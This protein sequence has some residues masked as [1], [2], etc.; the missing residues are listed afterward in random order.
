MGAGFLVQKTMQS[1]VS[2]DKMSFETCILFMG[3]LTYRYPELRR[4]MNQSEYKAGMSVLL[5]AEIIK[6]A[7][8]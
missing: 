1:I 5:L 8:S 4:L 6:P 2:G 7:V 3:F